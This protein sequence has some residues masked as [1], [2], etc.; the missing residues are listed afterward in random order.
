MLPGWMERH[1]KSNYSNVAKPGTNP[2]FHKRF[3]KT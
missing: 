1:L 3:N 2:N